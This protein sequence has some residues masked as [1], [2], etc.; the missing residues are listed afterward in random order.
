[1]K[2]K[3]WDYSIKGFREVEAIGILKYEGE[4]FFSFIDGKEYVCLGIE[5]GLFRMI[6]E[7]EEDYLYEIDNPRPMDGSSKGGKWKII[8][9]EYGKLEN[10]LD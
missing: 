2:A 1:M 7:S 9:D 4:T 6:D 8:K 3:V 5:N 10:I